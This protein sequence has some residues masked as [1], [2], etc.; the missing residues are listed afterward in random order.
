MALDP[1]GVDFRLV[2]GSKVV[3][4]YSHTCPETDWNAFERRLRHRKNAKDD[5]RL[6][7]DRF[8][9]PKWSKIGSKT[10]KVG[11]QIDQELFSESTANTKTVFDR[12]G[13]RFGRISG[14]KINQNLKTT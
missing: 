6:L 10:V 7:L 14:A 1:F 8:L 12:S 9:K 5:F 13:T 11:F 4:K 3:P 2:L